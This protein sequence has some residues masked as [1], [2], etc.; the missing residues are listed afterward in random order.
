MAN[1]EAK[2]EALL[3]I[4]KNDKQPADEGTSMVEQSP[5]LPTPESSLRVY[6]EK[7]GKSLNPQNPHYLFHPKIELPCFDRNNPREWIRKCNKFSLV[8]QIEERHKTY[9][10]EM[11]LKGKVDIWHEINSM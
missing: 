2:V 1:L 5:I 3:K 11:Y 8:Y 9:V 6:G 4:L 10:V 7:W